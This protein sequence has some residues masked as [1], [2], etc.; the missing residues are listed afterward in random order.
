MLPKLCNFTEFNP[1]TGEHWIQ[2]ITF[3]A[4]TNAAC[5]SSFKRL[6]SGQTHTARQQESQ[7]LSCLLSGGEVNKQLEIAAQGV[8]QCEVSATRVVV[9]ETADMAVKNCKYLP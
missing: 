7:Y 8:A 4:E 5:K 9:L 1:E 6:A 3:A 2:C